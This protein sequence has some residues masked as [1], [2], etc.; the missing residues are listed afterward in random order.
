MITPLELHKA[1]EAAGVPI[2]GVSVNK[3]GTEAAIQFDGATNQQ[4]AAAQAIVDAF[5]T[6][7]PRRPRDLAT[8]ITAAGAL[9]AQDRAKLQALVLAKFLQENPAAAKAVAVAI[10]G[11]EEVG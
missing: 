6:A 2:K 11:D 10:D 3:D 7:K 1:I 8:L 4:Q 9:S 5:K